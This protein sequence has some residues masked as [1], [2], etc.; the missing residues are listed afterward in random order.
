METY[1]IFVELTGG[2]YI[3]VEADSLDEAL[4]IATEEADPFNIIAWD[5][6]AEVDEHDI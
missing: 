3:E 1:K 5:I 6:E 2:Y 4:D